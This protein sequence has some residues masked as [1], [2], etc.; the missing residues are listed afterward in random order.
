MKNKKLLEVLSVLGVSLL[1][2][3]LSSISNNTIECIKT[4]KLMDEY[5]A[6]GFGE[7]YDFEEYENKI[8][9]IATIAKI[10][11]S[12]IIGIASGVLLKKIL[13]LINKK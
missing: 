6:S 10:I 1:G 5:E 9:N 7:E 2:S 3:S 4:E 11:S 8:H 12:C 13:K